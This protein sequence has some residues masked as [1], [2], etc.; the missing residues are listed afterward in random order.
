MNDHLG[1]LN[2]YKPINITSFGVLKKIK[3]NFFFNKIGHAG[4]LDPLAE[5]ILPVAIGKTTKLIQFISN[6]IKEYEFEIKWGEQTSTDDREGAVIDRSFNIP[7]Y[8]DINIKLKELTGTILQAPPKASAIKINGKR[9]YE[10]ARA[11]LPL[12]L[13]ERR[14]RVERL[15]LLDVLDKNSALFELHC[16]K[17]VYVRSI[18][19]DLGKT[20]GA[21]GHVGELRRMRVGS[22]DIGAAISLAQLEELKDIGGL[23]GRLLPLA[24][25]LAGVPVVCI[26]TEQ[27]SR[28]RHGQPVPLVTAPTDCGERIEAPALVCA[29]L[30][31]RPVALVDFS[32]GEIRP[33]RVFNYGA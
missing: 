7:N 10:L 17:G 15:D 11:N 32:G 30:A 8:K 24:E 20:L 31:K 26:D 25:G 21:E 27:A 9:A 6:Q 33:R 23:A 1:W 5:G 13:K 12:T 29:V 14:V 28:L 16:G 3:K 22:F 19:R 18:A 2:V 4:T